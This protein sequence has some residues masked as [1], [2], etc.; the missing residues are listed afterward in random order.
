M[1]P[2]SLSLPNPEASCPLI[3]Y[4]WVTA[5][6]AGYLRIN[7]RKSESG[8]VSHWENE[9]IKPFSSLTFPT[10]CPL[11]IDWATRPATIKSESKRTEP[12]ELSN[13][14]RGASISAGFLQS[15]LRPIKRLCVY[16]SKSD[17]YAYYKR[18]QYFGIYL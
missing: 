6:Q 1:A 10:L 15:S 8:W 18:V 11:A 5:L 17:V 2:V 13:V 7:N 4:L 3:A 12:G 14:Q 9:K 16:S